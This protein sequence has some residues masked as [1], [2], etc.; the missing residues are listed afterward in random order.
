[1][2]IRIRPVTGQFGA[3][4]NGLLAKL[5]AEQREDLRAELERLPARVDHVRL[6]KVLTGAYEHSA[7]RRVFVDSQSN[8]WSGKAAKDRKQTLANRKR[9][10]RRCTDE[11]RQIEASLTDAAR[12]TPD[13]GLF[14]A[15]LTH[16][17]NN[18]P[19]IGDEV[20]RRLQGAPGNPPWLDDRP[21]IE[22]EMA[23]AGVTTKA[24]RKLLLQLIGALPNGQNNAR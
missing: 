13:G 9:F 10:I 4:Y 1:V 11:R 17:R 12:R 24:T 19:L 8:A 6:E 21:R 7:H 3:V 14:L 18:D 22:R 20:L 15:A 2:A 23:A 16:L 5:T